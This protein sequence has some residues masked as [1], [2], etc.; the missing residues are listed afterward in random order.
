M[1]YKE[2]THPLGFIEALPKPTAAEL[3]DFYRERYF[4][5]GESSY[6]ATYSEAEL[7]NFENVARVAARTCER[8]SRPV[9]TLLDLGC[10]EGYFSRAF[11][12][13]GWSVTCADYSDF[14]IK[15]HNAELLP[16]LITGDVLETVGRMSEDRRA[17]GLI[18]LQNVLEHV[19]DPVSLLKGMR[20]LLTPES[21]VRVRVPNDYSDFQAELMRN[22]YTS[23]TWFAPPEHL[24]YFNR[25]ALLEVLH[26]CGYRVR[27]LQADFPIEVFLANPH[28]NYWRDRSLGKGAHL[29]R[30]FVENFLIGTDMDAYIRY[31]EAAGE[32]GFG[33]ELVAYGMPI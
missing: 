29:T 8:A 14:G 20:R 6:S 28:S 24:S 9:H 5:Q 33:R 13:F 4:Q 25:R 15:H 10:G 18:N 23:N 11:R 16:S 30:V 7:A 21:I 19:M 2:S 27:S 3:A 12:S 17:F 1:K 31:A 32:L 26:A 22:G